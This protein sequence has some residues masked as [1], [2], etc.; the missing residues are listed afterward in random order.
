MNIARKAIPKFMDGIDK[1]LR[2]KGSV[3]SSNWYELPFLP[4]RLRNL[5]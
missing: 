4:L 1:P 5:D 2:Y 3:H